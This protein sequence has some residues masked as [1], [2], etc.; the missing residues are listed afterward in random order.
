[1]EQIS[2]SILVLYTHCLSDPERYKKPAVTM[3]MKGRL[4]ILPSPAE[5]EA[6]M[7]VPDSWGFGH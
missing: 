7:R 5:A 3:Q 2:P 4:R 6:R 1:M